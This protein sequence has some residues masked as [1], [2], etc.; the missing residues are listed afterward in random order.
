[1]GRIRIDFDIQGQPVLLRP[2]AH[3]IDQVVHQRGQRIL[4]GEYVNLARLDFREIED[5]V[6]DGK[7]AQGGGVDVFSVR[8]RVLFVALPQNHLIHADDSIYGRPYLMA[9]H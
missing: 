3:K 7:Q 5:V 8:Q 2:Q 4:R 1:M 6:Y 9:H